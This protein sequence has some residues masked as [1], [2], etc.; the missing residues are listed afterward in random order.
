MRGGGGSEGGV[1]EW[2]VAKAC[3]LLA[4]VASCGPTPTPSPLAPTTPRPPP[5]GAQGVSE[6]DLGEGFG[7]FGIAAN[8]VPAMVDVVKAKGERGGLCAW[9]KVWHLCKRH[10]L[11][12]PPLAR[13]PGGKVAR[14][15]GPVKGGKTVIAFVEDPT[16]EEEE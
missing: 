7:H 14:E 9:F 4:L 1:I 13:A 5:L 16:G 3:M 6:Y 2:G 8:N 15:A 10:T 11:P 12:R